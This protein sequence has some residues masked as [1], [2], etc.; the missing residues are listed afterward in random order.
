M[1]M[2]G[3]NSSTGKI[4]TSVTDVNQIISF[5]ASISTQGLYK[6]QEV[7]WGIIKIVM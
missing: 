4:P 6:V 5:R 7:A 1:G 2:S 3:A